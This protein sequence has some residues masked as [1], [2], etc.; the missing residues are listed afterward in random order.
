MEGCQRES[1]LAASLVSC[2]KTSVMSFLRK[3]GY[4]SQHDRVTIFYCQVNKKG[5][6]HSHLEQ[7]GSEEAQINTMDFFC[8]LS[9]NISCPTQ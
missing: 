3:G 7:K 9:R 4:Y 8:K 5:K 1:S 2:W 6:I